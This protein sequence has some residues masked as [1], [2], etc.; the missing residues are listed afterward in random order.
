MHN[1]KRDIYELEG[2]HTKLALENEELEIL[3]ELLKEEYLLRIKKINSSQFNLFKDNS[4]S[5]YHNICNVIDHKK[6][7]PKKERCINKINLSIVKKFKFF[8]VIKKE[9]G[10]FVIT[11]E[12]KIG[13]E[14]I[15]WRLVRPNQNGDVGPIH[16]DSWFWELNQPEEKNAKRIKVWLPVFCEE[17]NTGFRYVPNS[18]KKNWRYSYEFKDHKYKPIPQVK[19]SKSE[20]VNFIGNPGQ[21][22]VFNDK[23]LHG[24]YTTSE[25]TRV[26]LELTLRIA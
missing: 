6:L 11:D 2:V 15:Y 13:R 12:D 19:L 3:R 16:A 17:N 8:N 4:M 21:I 20:I 1:I 25:K 7:W 5:N 26:S 9:L 18:H 24:G 22:I 10:D 23:L 14:E